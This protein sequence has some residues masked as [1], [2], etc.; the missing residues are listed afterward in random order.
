MCLIPIDKLDNLKTDSKEEELLRTF[1]LYLAHLNNIPKKSSIR[2][3][4]SSIAYK[5]SKI[6]KVLST[7]LL[8]PLIILFLI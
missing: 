3:G 7:N 5:S 8:N 2:T 6:L 1:E 4:L